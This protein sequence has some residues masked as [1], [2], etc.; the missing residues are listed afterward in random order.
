MDINTLIIAA[1]VGVIASAL[2]G[3]VGGVIVGGK[4][5][6]NEIAAMMGS[7]YGPLAGIGG[8]ALGLAVLVLTGR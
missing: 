3:A 7:F 8:V 5:I 1:T 4:S 6:G 2:G